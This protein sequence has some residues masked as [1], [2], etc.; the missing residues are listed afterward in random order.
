MNGVVEMQIAF[1]II[2]RPYPRFYG[3][4]GKQAP[5]VASRTKA[6]IATISPEIPER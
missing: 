5:P 2:I 6:F 4:Q 3:E 1:Y